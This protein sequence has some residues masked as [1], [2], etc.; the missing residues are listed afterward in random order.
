MLSTLAGDER[1]FDLEIQPAGNPETRQRLSY[2]I[3]RRPPA[4]SIATPAPGVYSEEIEVRLESEEGRVLYQLLPGDGEP[5]EYRKPVVLSGIPGTVTSYVLE[6]VVVG[7][8]GSGSRVETHRYVVDRS[9][10]TEPHLRV[11]S[12]VPGRFA[13]AQLLYIASRG[14]EEVRYSLD[15][16]D[17]RNGG[18][19]Y[20]GPVL[21]AREGTVNLSVVGSTSR[22]ETIEE[23]VV[24]EGER[25][26]MLSTPQG[27][28]D[29][30]LFVDLEGRRDFRYRLEDSPVSRTDAVLTRA[31]EIRPIPGTRRS[32]ILRL[33]GS[34]EEG[35]PDFRYTF[36]LDS[37][38]VRPPLIHLFFPESDRIS[39][40]LEKEAQVETEYAVFI[41]GRPYR[42]GVYSGPVDVTLPP[43]VDSAE[44]V[45]RARSRSGTGSWSD[46]AEERFVVSTTAPPAVPL[47][48]FPE[49]PSPAKQFSFQIPS[50]LVIRYELRGITE[51]ERRVTR[52]SGRLEDGDILSI[53][54]STRGRSVLSYATFDPQGNASEVRSV[55]L[56]LDHEP[57]AEPQISV[58][59]LQARIRG[60][61]EVYFRVISDDSSEVPDFGVYQNPFDLPR[62][63]ARRVGYTIEAYGRDSVGNTS[64]I[65]SRRVFVDDRPLTVPPLVGVEDGEYYS[66]E[67]VTVSAA[68]ATPG[69]SLHYTLSLDG[70]VPPVPT[71]TSPV[72]EDP[73]EIFG[74]DGETVSVH[75]RLRV[76]SQESGRFGEER[77]LRFV[78]DRQ[79]PDLP[80]LLGVEDGGVY[81]GSREVTLS[82]SETDGS[83]FLILSE[84]G[85]VEN[86][87]R[88]PYEGP[89]VL[90]VP[91]GTRSEFFISVEIVDAAGN[92]NTSSSP[93]RVVIDRQLPEAP[94]VS[95][96]YQDG[97]A[98]LR[99]EGGDGALFYSLTRRPGVSVVPGPD[100]T[101]YTGPVRL[102][103]GSY[104]LS[105]REIDAAG[106]HS[107]VTYSSEIH[108]PAP[109]EVSESKPVVLANWQGGNGV[110]IWPE[111]HRRDLRYRLSFLGSE[112]ILLYDG[113]AEFPIPEGTAEVVV[114][115]SLTEGEGLPLRLQ[116]PRPESPGVPEISPADGYRAR[117]DVDVTATAPG[118]LRYE[119]STTGPP[120]AVSRR[121]PEWPGTLRLP[122][123]D[124]E[125]VTFEIALRSFTESGA[126]EVE[127]RT[128][129]VDRAPPAAP[130]LANA[131]DGEFYDDSRQIALEHD[132]AEV[133]YRVL[134]NPDSRGS[135]G[136]FERY[137]GPILLEAVTG[138]LSGYRI[139][140]YSVD[141]VGNRSPQTA[142]WNVYV[143]RETIYVAP[144]GS[145]RGA[146]TRE[147]PFQTLGR[148]LERA[149]ESNR[150][151]IFLG[152]GVY[153]ISQP[154][155]SEEAL[156]I[157]GGF[158]PES[159]RPSASGET[160]IVPADNFSGDALITSYRGSVT[161]SRLALASS[162]SFEGSLLLVDDVVTSLDSVSLSNSGGH[163][164]D[165]REGSLSLRRVTLEQSGTTSEA[166]VLRGTA[167]TIES[168]V[169]RAGSFGSDRSVALDLQSSASLTLDR[170]RIEAYG[171]SRATAISA[172]NSSLEILQ[173]TFRV[174][175][176]R[177]NAQAVTARD[178]GVLVEDSVLQADH[179]TRV[180]NLLVS[181]D[182]TLAVVGSVLELSGNQGAVGIVASGGQVDVRGSRFVG[183][184]LNDFTYGIQARGIEGIFVNNVF[185][186]G[187][188][189]EYIAGSLVDSPSQWIHNTFLGY[190][191][192][193][194]IQLLNIRGQGETLFG[195][196]LAVQGAAG[197]GTGLVVSD[198]HQLEVRGNLFAGWGTILAT[199]DREVSSLS[200]LEG[201]RVTGVVAGENGT[202]SVGDS[203]GRDGV[204]YRLSATS[205]A[206][207][208]AVELPG[209]E[210]VLFDIEGQR[211]PAPVPPD[212]S[213][214]QAYEGRPDVG[215]DEYYP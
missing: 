10:E 67:S 155:R 45:L 171:I 111:A 84:E 127:R 22:G 80:T 109:N 125:T 79:T 142:V 213:F 78:I 121:S 108:V 35:T 172:A 72:L 189:G 141:Q 66:D 41:E 177:G 38:V 19:R 107:P 73:L 20:V 75:L 94:G 203:I 209:A 93:T 130:Q 82:V 154:L 21:I 196:N 92:R 210:E 139:E 190:R 11:I 12:P 137:D 124:G 87:R 170:S 5:V 153:E 145:D 81:R 8:R 151:T 197:A 186:A 1:R 104:L 144:Q 132:T 205:P 138:E 16:S 180:A 44:G 157:Q 30:P 97:V 60:S 42:S 31:L 191:A 152:A 28:Y 193:P 128:F 91:E 169:L 59:G 208:R 202:M 117:E 95:L 115:Y 18:N 27:Y 204:P 56:V 120:Q 3:D 118:T 143:D 129:V 146:G 162:P 156:A 90:D 98:L 110:L 200:L 2:T 163:A 113:P 74:A 201:G 149:R 71:E 140:A 123:R 212:G 168:S 133:F 32:V 148:A 7:D 215:A 85:E 101:L 131:Q 15:G 26:S 34:P 176:T 52:R 76:R 182:G 46:F 173:S 187:Q 39:F 116:V 135:G 54:Y 37:R 198:R 47:T 206:I 88:V 112:E 36:I 100:S 53:P 62:F 174:G 65:V 105:A 51:P 147:S 122:G 158:D 136:V 29:G 77:E 49:G 13:N 4:P 57:P 89:V 166:V 99:L 150:E 58:E 185:Q 83:V 195:N 188:V 183:T 114:E 24:Y 102:D 214:R 55:E 50:D 9:E 181:R 164:I 211:R 63:S 103:P 119:I 106:N 64:A 207:D 161:M 17:P 175:A 43:G 61:E 159:W 199:D 134:R 6:S 23:S 33:N 25:G 194:F 165:A 126:G 167:A 160:V 192:S 178:G 48:V 70:T 96:I 184:S 14:L 69:F 40:A 86:P 68:L 179:Q